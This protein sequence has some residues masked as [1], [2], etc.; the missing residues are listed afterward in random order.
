MVA[1]FAAMFDHLAEG[2]FVMGIGLGGLPSDFE[3]FHLDDAMA[4]GKMTLESIDIILKIWTG[5]PP[6]RIEASSGRSARTSGTGRSSA[7]GSC[8][9]LTSSRIR[10]SRSPA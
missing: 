3:L 1:G 2:R 9:S 4:R 7:S 10:R 8:P 5:E 6:Y